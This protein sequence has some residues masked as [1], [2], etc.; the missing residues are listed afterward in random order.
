MFDVEQGFVTAM[1]KN[2][3]LS[4]VKL[5]KYNFK[6]PTP[7]TKTFSYRTSITPLIANFLTFAQRFGTEA[8]RGLRM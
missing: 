8:R 6:N 5:R 3:T 2:T 4:K 1:T 7:A